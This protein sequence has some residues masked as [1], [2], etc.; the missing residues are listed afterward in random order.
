MNIARNFRSWR[1]YRETVDQLTRLGE[2]ELEDLGI[3][4]GMINEVAREAARR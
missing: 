2:H 3:A 4:P 1:K